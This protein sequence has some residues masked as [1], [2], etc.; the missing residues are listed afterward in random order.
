M[1]TTFREPAS[2]GARLSRVGERSDPSDPGQSRFVDLGGPVHYVEWEGPPERTFLL[3][4]GLGGSCLQW[5]LVAPQLA[6]RGRVFAMDL[7]GFGHTPR[8]GR[9]SKLTANRALVSHV[10]EEVAGGPVILAGNSMGG[11]I[12]VMQA[13]VEPAAVEG[14]ILTGSVYPWARGGFPSP[15]VMGG[16]ALYRVPRV[17][18]WFLRQR[19]TRMSAERLVRLGFRLTM[20][21]PAAV[22]D[23]L[24]RA[25]A[26]LLVERM[27]DPDA[28]AAFLEAARSLLRL[29][30]NRERARAL[31]EDVKCPV[32]AIHG[33]LDRFVPAA[34][35]WAA[36]EAHPDWMVRVLPGVGHVPQLEAPERWI[37]A[38]DAWLAGTGPR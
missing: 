30:E 37:A 32:V 36:T 3:L 31:L 17:G 23:W 5:S 13:A 11:G 20:V 24:V 12:A 33:R 8:S 18:E 26:D 2:P 28:G 38:V 27:A 15:V 14:L 21:N 7:A 29:G 22:P 19:N 4:H 35:A 1:Q 16:F 10:I 9:S 34:F 25:H 6:T